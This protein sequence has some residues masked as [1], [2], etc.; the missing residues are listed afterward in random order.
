MTVLLGLELE[1]LPPTVNMMYRGLH[2]HR[3]KTKD[4]LIYQSEVVS[5]LREAYG[6]CPPL[7]GRVGLF[8]IFT[9]S[10]RRRW[11]IDNRV[12]ALQDCLAPAG[13]IHDDTQVDLLHVERV[14]GDF[15]LTEVRLY[16]LEN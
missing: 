5:R 15:N 10:S 3:Y 6:E 16:V 7:E 8:I 11:D 1:G 2:G 9:T 12:K 13:V 4:T 14:H